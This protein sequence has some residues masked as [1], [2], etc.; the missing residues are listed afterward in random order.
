MKFLRHPVRAIREPFG[1]AG[2]IVACVALLAALGGSAYAA[3]GGLSGKQKKEVEKI[4]KTYAGKPGPAGKAGSAGPAGPAGS[5]GPQGP[6]GAAGGKGELGPQGPAGPQGPE[7]EEGEP[8]PE[9]SPWTAGGTLPPE[10]TETGVW[11]PKIANAEEGNYTYPISFTVPLA[12]GLDEEHAVIVNEAGGETSKPGCPGQANGLPTAEP[13]YF[14][15][16]VVEANE[17]LVI[18][19]QL[20]D[21]SDEFGTGRTGT[22]IFT[23]IDE[24]FSDVFGTWAVTAAK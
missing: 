18:G 24:K 12:A 9:G 17:A 5:A 8:G 1:T 2:L 15:A 7:G 10:A 16:Y 23:H 6:A 11:G 4:A 19:A 14:C 21:T 3:S 22:F 13:G 20:P